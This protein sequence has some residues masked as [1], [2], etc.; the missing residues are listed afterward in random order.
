MYLLELFV[1]Y[2]TSARVG[3]DQGVAISIVLRHTAEKLGILNQSWHRE[4]GEITVSFNRRLK[5]R[6]LPTDRERGQFSAETRGEPIRGSKL[7]RLPVGY[8]I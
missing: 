2:Q 8:G 7:Q 3:F 1:S 5:P 4:G 6:V